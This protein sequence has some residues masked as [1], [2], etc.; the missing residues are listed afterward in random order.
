MLAMS[1]GPACIVAHAQLCMPSDHAGHPLHT[2]RTLVHQHKYVHKIILLLLAPYFMLALMLGIV[3]RIWL[4]LCCPTVHKPSSP[5]EAQMHVACCCCK[6]YIRL[7][8]CRRAFQMQHPGGSSSSLEGDEHPFQTL[9]TQQLQCSITGSS[10][11]PPSDVASSPIVHSQPHLPL[12]QPS[13]RDLTSPSADTP[14][15]NS[16]SAAPQAAA[17]TSHQL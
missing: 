6:A 9:S 1:T 14:T 5:L 2:S 11:R 4:R 10:L 16:C 13:Q 12:T 7:L 8:S 3:E 17:S 15:H